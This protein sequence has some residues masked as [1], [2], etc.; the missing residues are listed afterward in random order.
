MEIQTYKEYANR[1]QEKAKDANNKTK[2][3]QVFVDETRKQLEK[4]NKQIK[5]IRESAQGDAI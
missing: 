2:E 3:G 1:M 4:K 5:N